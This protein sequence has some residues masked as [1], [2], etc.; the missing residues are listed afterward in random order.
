MLFPPKNR[1][2]SCNTK[3]ISHALQKDAIYL[4]NLSLHPLDH[5][6]QSYERLS[7]PGFYFTTR[8]YHTKSLEHGKLTSNCDNIVSI[9]RHLIV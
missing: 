6:F 3:K 5:Y 8:F 1:M 2:K 9:V 4:L 7:G